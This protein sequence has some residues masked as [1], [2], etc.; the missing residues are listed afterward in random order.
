MSGREDEILRVQHIQNTELGS[1]HTVH[2]TTCG[3]YSLIGG[4]HF[5]RNM[6][7]YHFLITTQFG[8]MISTYTLM[9]V[10]SVILAECIA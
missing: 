6:T 9:P 7:I 8:C 4:L 2:L 5:G 1:I 10:R 3:S